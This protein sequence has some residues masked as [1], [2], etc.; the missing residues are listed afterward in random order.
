M[1]Q[2]QRKSTIL[3]SL[4]NYS[5]RRYQFQPNNLAYQQHYKKHT[6]EIG[7]LT[8]NKNSYKRSTHRTNAC[9]NSI[10]RSKRNFL[11]RHIQKMK[12]QINTDKESNRPLRVRKIVAE[13]QT[14]CEGYFKQSGNYKIDPGHE[15]R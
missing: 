1:S 15:R 8:E 14:G 13:L 3:V 2:Q 7:W 4:F 5:M 9:P 10:G 6:P 11:Y 12:A